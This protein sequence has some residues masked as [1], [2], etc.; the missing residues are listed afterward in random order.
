M[1]AEAAHVMSSLS[2]NCYGN[3]TSLHDVGTEAAN[4]LSFSRNVL[5]EL[6]GVDEAGL[7]FTSGGTESN[8]LSIISLALAYRS[9]GNHLIVSAGEHP[10]VDSAM[11]YLQQQGFQ[12]TTIPFNRD[13][14]IQLDTLAKAITKDTILI[15]V[16]HIN[17]E[18]GAIQ[19]IAE[20][21]ELIRERSILL[22][23]DCVQSFG[24]VDIRP[25][26]SIV[27]SVTL[28]SHKVYGPKGVGA[29]YIHPKH[30]VQPVFPGFVHEHGF[31]GGTVNVPGIAAF[32]TAAKES[33]ENGYASSSYRHFR[34]I[35]VNELKAYGNLFTI[36]ESVNECQQLPQII[37]LGVRHIEGQLVMLELNRKGFAI[38]T[39]SAC[40]VG[41]Q[42]TSKI[43]YA[44]GIP[45]DQA[46]EF[47]R[48]SFGRGTTEEN[49]KK[50]TREL[51]N[52]AQQYSVKI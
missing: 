11:S 24:K 13:G 12:V 38:S 15:S 34:S 46:R 16:Q 25:I 18:M 20:I 19:P 29:V 10:S 44:M 26:T 17:P 14:I 23:C 41:Q 6:L 42:Q 47:I 52:I 8:V 37:G 22:H 21:A 7:F 40:Q 9:R 30:R 32:V 35:L 3:T 36:Y 1:S 43:M 4:M 50:L 2:Q 39:G 48:I 45:P 28:S 51:L 27:D 5:A 33:I 31:R 49:V